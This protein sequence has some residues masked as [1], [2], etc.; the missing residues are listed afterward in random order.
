M[1]PELPP[2]IARAAVA[3]LVAAGAAVVPSLAPPA[4]AQTAAAPEARYDPVTRVLTLSP[5][6]GV[7]PVVTEG[8]DPPR[9]VAEWPGTRGTAPRALLFG[10]GMVYRFLVEAVG[11]RTR[12][13]VFL[14]AP[15]DGGWTVA[16][17][18]ATTQIK[19]APNDPEA[20]FVRPMPK[21]T[22]RPAPQMPLGRITPAPVFP[23]AP[24]PRP[25]PGMAQVPEL[26]PGGPSPGP[27]EPLPVPNPFGGPGEAPDDGPTA[28]PQPTITATPMPVASASPTPTP[29]PSMVP[30]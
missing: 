16:Y 26:P 5:P 21:R 1:R 9:L 27:N 12:V 23:M 17:T 14:R 6:P 19:L 4:A 29:E 11:D 28:A 15:L 10:A 20:D 24:T 2:A 7:V 13:T 18:G 22:P 25:L 30:T 8:E 3:V